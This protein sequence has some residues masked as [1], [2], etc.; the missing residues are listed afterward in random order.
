MFSCSFPKFSGKHC[1]SGPEAPSVLER[2]VPFCQCIPLLLFWINF[3]VSLTLEFI[4]YNI[5]REIYIEP[6]SS[7]SYHTSNTL[8][9][10][11]Q[12]KL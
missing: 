12:V 11:I 1:L 3:A 7:V 6:N 8:V 2:S 10:I 5:Y 4:K 9:L